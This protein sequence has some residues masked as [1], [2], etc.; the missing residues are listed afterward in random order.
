MISL[1]RRAMIALTTAGAALAACSSPNPRLYTLAPAP[2]VVQ[3]RGP[4]VV[5]LHQVAIARYLERPEI[6]RSSE[7]YRLDVMANDTWGEPL[8]AMIGRVLAENLS[9]RLPGT[10]F[11][12]SDSA[13]SAKENAA[14]GVNILRMDLDATRTLILAAQASVTFIEPERP[15]LMRSLRT[16]V[17]VPSGRIAEEVRAMSIALGRLADEI[18]VMLHEPPRPP[19]PRPAHR[20]RHRH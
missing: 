8:S 3:G 10:T 5:L 11:V 17:P 18:A 4:H 2:G 15:G 7:H 13:I 6:V 16:T 14:V 19:P 1:D 9:Q 20:A 12:T